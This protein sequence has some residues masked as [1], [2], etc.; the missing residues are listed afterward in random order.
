MNEPIKGLSGT[1]A[2]RSIFE[3]QVEVREIRSHG[4][5]SLCHITPLSRAAKI[6][7]TF[8]HRGTQVKRDF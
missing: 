6:D 5:E 3:D 7:A 8:P 1:A 4:W 2:A